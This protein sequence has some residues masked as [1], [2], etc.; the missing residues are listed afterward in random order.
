MEKTILGTQVVTQIGILVHD[1]DAA[2]RTY[3][4]FFGVDV[5]EIIISDT[6]DKTNMRYKGQPTQARCKQSFFPVGGACTIELI[7]PDHE[8]SEWR[9]AL[10]KKG[11]G[12]HHIAFEVKGMDDVIHCLEQNRMPLTQKGDYTGGRYAYIDSVSDL[13]VMIELLENFKK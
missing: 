2:T 10:N 13:K 9:D 7:E 1:I 5:P 11:E 3:A 12:V 4:E 6:L 8:P